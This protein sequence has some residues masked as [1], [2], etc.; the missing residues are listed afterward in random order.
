[1]VMEEK[2]TNSDPFMESTHK[3]SI[4]PLRRADVVARVEVSKEVARRA[5]LALA[6]LGHAVRSG[7]HPEN[8]RAPGPLPIGAAPRARAARVLT[9]SSRAAPDPVVS[10]PR[11]AIIGADPAGP[12]APR[13]G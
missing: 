8:P 11:G 12:G 5:L 7:G 13:A 10:A 9:R 6:R 1:M 4:Y 3:H 2:L